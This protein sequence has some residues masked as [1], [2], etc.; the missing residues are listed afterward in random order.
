MR[1][2]KYRNPGTRGSPILENLVIL[3]G[4]TGVSRCY[5]GAL[6]VA[7]APRTHTPA[8]TRWLPA[9]SPGR[10]LRRKGT[11]ATLP[12]VKLAGRHQQIANR[13]PR[14]VQINAE[15]DV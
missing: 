10:L 7:A 13:E 4:K 14:C 5:S 6:S 12:S 15:V 11:D 2:L 1:T 3:R 9:L 8:L